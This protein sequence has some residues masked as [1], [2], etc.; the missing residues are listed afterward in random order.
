MDSAKKLNRRQFLRW[1]ALAAGAATLSSCA[2]KTVEK[3][4]QQTVEVKETVVQEATVVKEATVVQTVDWPKLRWVYNPN[5]QSQAQTLAALNKFQDDNKIRVEFEPN[6]GDW[7]SITQKMLASFA[8]GDAPDIFIQYGPYVRMC[9][10]K[11]IVLPYNPFIEKESFDMT[12]FVQGQIDAGTKNGQIYGF[13]NYC[14][15]WGTWVNLDL[16]EQAGVPKPDNDSWDINAYLEAAQKVVK[17]DS[18]GNLLQA[19][20]ELNNALEFGLSPAIWSYGGEV[21]DETRTQ[22]RM[23]EPKAMEALQVCA[24]MVWKYKLTPSAAESAAL[25]TAGGWGLFPSGKTGM[26]DDGSWFF[27]CNMEAIADKFHYTVI[28]HWKGPDGKRATFCTTDLWMTNAKTKFPDACWTFL[29]WIGGP[30]MNRVR[31]TYEHL[32]PAIKSIAPEWVKA[33]TDYAVSLNPKESDLDL[34]P[35]IDAYEYARPMFWWAC[36]TAVME[37]LQPVLDQIYTTGK[38]TVKDLIPPICEKID[39][40]TC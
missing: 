16:F 37:I 18:N 40:I 22:C 17:R 10:D 33:A 2:P 3:V 30:D 34:Q 5:T 31:M 15:I 28:P 6:P 4:V 20:T 29:K 25:A 19:G 7:G 35:F 21:S 12:Q 24:D 27:C 39:K 13:P 26:R 38:G 9:I 36:H 11:S 8:A 14:G 23:S 32:Q 1:S